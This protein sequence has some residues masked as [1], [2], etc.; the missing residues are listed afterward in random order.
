MAPP[1]STSTPLVVAPVQTTSRLT[2]KA[3]GIRNPVRV[4]WQVFVGGGTGVM[5]GLLLLT[6]YFESGPFAKHG[7]QNRV[8]AFAEPP[9]AEKFAPPSVDNKIQ[10]N[11]NANDNA[12]EALDR[13]NQRRKLVRNAPN[14]REAENRALGPP[15]AIREGNFGAPPQFQEPPRQMDLARMQDALLKAKVPQGARIWWCQ[16]GFFTFEA[17]DYITLTD[18]SGRRK[19]YRVVGATEKYLELESEQRDERV[20]LYVD[21]AESSKAPFKNFLPLFSDGAWITALDTEAYPW[22]SGAMTDLEAGCQNTRNEVK[23]ATRT[24]LLQAQTTAENKKVK[25]VPFGFSMASERERF[26]A[27]GFVS[28]AKP[29]WSITETHIDTCRKAQK[30][31]DIAYNRIATRV[32]AEHEKETKAFLAYHKWRHGTWPLAVV[33]WKDPVTGKEEH[34]VLLSDGSVDGSDSELN[35][36]FNGGLILVELGDRRV[37]LRPDEM[38]REFNVVGAGKPTTGIF[39]F[40]ALAR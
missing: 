40:E 4:L 17:A 24:L 19:F 5:I 38:G 16:K 13:K 31:I 26:E 10:N 29:L 32:H 23:Q 1:V 30:T 33:L 35:W 8:V 12:G 25:E 34:H 21:H 36:K 15:D 2:R 14:D 28:W 3:K 27:T 22:L 9:K 39:L 6:Y 20:H 11:P 7:E 18:L 37:K